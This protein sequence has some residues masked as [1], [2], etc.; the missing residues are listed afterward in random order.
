MEGDWSWHGSCVARRRTLD[1]RRLGMS[2]SLSFA[3]VSMLAF[4][5]Q[6]LIFVNLYPAHRVRFFT[7][8]IWAWGFFTAS[9]GIKLAGT[10]LP[11]W[12]DLNPLMN[13]AT[14]AAT[15]FVLAAGLAYRFDY[16]IERRGVLAAALIIAAAC[17]TGDLTEA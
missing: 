1:G 7:Y 3:F 12:V 6:F 16:R 13:A 17:L 14:V 8:F 5:I 9:K 11:G 2:L 10:V 15:L 4:A